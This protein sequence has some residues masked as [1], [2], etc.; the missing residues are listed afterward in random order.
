MMT[1]REE[2][3]MTREANKAQWAE[4]VQAQRASGKSVTAFCREHGI[5]SKTFFRW[6]RMLGRKSVATTTA[7]RG[8]GSRFARVEI[9]RRPEF[10]AVSVRLPGGV[11]IESSGYPDPMWIRAIICSLVEEGLQ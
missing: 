8:E 2:V 7:K 3:I 6:A 5:N 9:A 11:A 4:R 10:L 1:I